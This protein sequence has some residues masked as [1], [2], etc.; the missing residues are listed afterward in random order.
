MNGFDSDD[1]CIEIVEMNNTPS[2]HDWR[3][4]GGH[5]NLGAYWAIASC[6]HYGSDPADSEW[7]EPGALE[8]ANYI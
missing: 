6:V 3:P 1:D 4:F 7:D 8:N 2:L 5:M